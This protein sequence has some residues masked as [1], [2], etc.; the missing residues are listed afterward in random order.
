MSD[1]QLTTRQDLSY[2]A[3]YEHQVVRLD[4]VARNGGPAHI[5]LILRDAIHDVVRSLPAGRLYVG[6]R[7]GRLT[8]ATP[9][10]TDL[11]GVTLLGDQE[12][13]GLAL[14]DHWPRSDAPEHWGRV[15]GALAKTLR[16]VGHR[17]NPSVFLKAMH[18]SGERNEAL[19]TVVSWC[20]REMPDVHVLYNAQHGADK[21]VG[22]QRRAGTRKGLIGAP[23]WDEDDSNP[24]KG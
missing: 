1:T 4:C 8:F 3:V 6:I 2:P 14:G 18:S 12:A 22:G 20:R 16:A 11:V 9:E 17:L 21:A 19:A 15:M 5:D 24:P 13:A 7:A 10:G 23:G